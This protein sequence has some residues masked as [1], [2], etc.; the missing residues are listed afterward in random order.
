[1]ASAYIYA[2][3]GRN[4]PP[5][6]VMLS[7]S[8]SAYGAQ[9]VFGRPLGNWEVRMMNIASNVTSAYKAKQRAENQAEWAKENPGRENTI[10]L[11]LEAALKQGY[12]PNA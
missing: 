7:N 1:M 4:D 12:N 11:A 2:D 8:V 9:A 5:K 3:G 10:A 6:Y